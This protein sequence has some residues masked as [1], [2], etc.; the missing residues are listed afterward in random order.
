MDVIPTKRSAWRDPGTD[1]TANVPEVRR[2]FD[3]PTH[4][5]TGWSETGKIRFYSVETRTHSNPDSN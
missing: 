4:R 2:S 5:M 1:F 3:D